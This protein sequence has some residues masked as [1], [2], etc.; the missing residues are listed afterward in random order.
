M[1]VRIGPGLPLLIEVMMIITRETLEEAKRLFNVDQVAWDYE[2]R[3]DS[4][5]GTYCTENGCPDDHPSGVYELD[6]PEVGDWPND[7]CLTINEDDAKRVV[8]GHNM[9]PFLIQRIAKL[10]EALTFYSK[11]WHQEPTGDPKYEECDITDMEPSDT[12]SEDK[13][14]LARTTLNDGPWPLTDS[15]FSNY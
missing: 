2:E 14:E 9:L 1:S 3:C 15:T 4:S 13:G 12:L 10:E 11:E 7:N 5:C 6:G 8:L